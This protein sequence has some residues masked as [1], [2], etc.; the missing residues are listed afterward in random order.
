[1]SVYEGLK[2]Y[3]PYKRKD[4]RLHVIL[5]EHGKNNTITKRITVSYPK[6]LVEKYLGRYLVEP[7]TVDHIDGN[8]SNNELS[9]LRVVNREIHERSHAKVRTAIKKVCLVCGKEFET[10][11]NSRILCNSKHCAGMSAHIDGYNKGNSFKRGGK[12]VL[13]SNRSLIEEI[14][15]VEVA[16]SGN[17]LVDNPEQGK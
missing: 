14:Q 5:I 3:G 13:V 10:F 1:M 12:N 2:C 9:N 17:S 6:Y 16:N 11:D 8:F 15:S 7:E 4:G